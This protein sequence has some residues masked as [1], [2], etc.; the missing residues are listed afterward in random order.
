[1][2]IQHIRSLID[3]GHI[4]EARDEN[5]QPSSLDLSISGEVYRMRGTFLPRK[6]ESVRTLLDDGILFPVSLTQPLELNGVYLA[7]LNE[8]LDLP[9]NIYAVTN[10]K[11]S[12]GRV[13]L[14]TR[15]IVNGFPAFDQVPRGYQ[16]EL[17]LE[18]IP[19]SF[20]VQLSYGER[21]NQM[22]FHSGDTR[23]TLD[24]YHLYDQTYGLLRDANEQPLPLPE[25]LT[26]HGISMSIDLSSQ[27]IIGYKCTPT[28]TKVLDYSS[29][30]HNPLDFFEAIPRP[31]NGQFIMKRDEFYIFAT[32]EGIRVPREF[33]VEMAPY[34]VSMGEFRSHYA[35]FF[36][37]GFGFGSEG[38]TLGM[39]AVLEVFT[40]D[41][42]FVLRDG[43]PICRMIY[44]KLTAPAEVYYGDPKLSS[45]Y[46]KQI[47]PR[48]SKHFRQE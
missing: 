30:D 1:L 39:P 4:K 7:R 26:Q 48:L 40:H 23:L 35:G 3:Q 5:L 44:E 9:E 16:G 25:M 21:L 2:A 43:Q 28:T 32:K 33:A 8:S 47:G 27:E 11:S 41:Q 37:P 45:N 38:E 34:D 46:Y 29:S 19:K 14:Q 10:N 20:P 24:E 6:G 36:D 15:L 17:W 12:S 22:M 42:D 13:N 31:S 18:I